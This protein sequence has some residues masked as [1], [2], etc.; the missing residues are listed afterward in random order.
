MAYGTVLVA[1]NLDLD[2]TG[3]FHKFLHVDTVILKRGSSFLLGC[4]IS[5]L[6][7]FFSSIPHAYPYHHH[8]Q[9]L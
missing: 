4:I 6:N 1:G 9:S 5:L 7:F 2:M 8:L 3:L